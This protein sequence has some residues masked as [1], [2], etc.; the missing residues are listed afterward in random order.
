[1]AYGEDRAQLDTGWALKQGA[2][3]GIIAGI[4]FAMAEM[5]GAALIQGNPFLMPL[6]AIASVP[7]GQPPPQIMQGYSTITF[8]L[9]GLVTHMVF[10]AIFGIIFALAVAKVPALRSRMVLIIAA[11]VWGFIL[12]VVN[13]Y[14][15]GPA[16]GRPWFAQTPALLQFIYHTFFFGTVLGVYLRS[17]LPA[18]RTRTA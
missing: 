16:L 13:F 18:M 2:I 7:I 12:W 17:V 9:I 3:G 10:S 4:V 14:V 11:S 6:A 15:L 5:I 8:V 1:M